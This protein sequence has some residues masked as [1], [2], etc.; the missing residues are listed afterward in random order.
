MRPDIVAGLAVLALGAVEARAQNAVTPDQV[1]DHVG[2]TVTV[3][4]VAAIAT[5]PSGAT[6]ITLG[7]KNFTAVILPASAALFRGLP[8][9]S[10]KTVDI[11]GTV[12]MFQGKPEIILNSPSQIVAK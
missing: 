7:S 1:A 11:T 3:E 6:I 10:G 12:Q 5:A 9:L 8:G 4:G 2:G